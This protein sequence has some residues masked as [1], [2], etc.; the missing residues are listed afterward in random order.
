MKAK[1]ILEEA[2]NNG[3]HLEFNV[4]VSNDE[5]TSYKDIIYYRNE[6]Q[7]I[8]EAVKKLEKE[9]SE[10]KEKAILQN[11][12]IYR[13]HIRELDGIS[14]LTMTVQNKDMKLL[15]SVVDSLMNEMSNGFIF[16][17]NINPDHSVSFVA[18]SNC[19]ISAGDIV[20]EASLLSEGRGGGSP[21][22]A[23]GGGR[24]T[25]KLEEIIQ[26]IEGVIKAH[27]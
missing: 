9:Y 18:K 7:T 16:L 8:Q 5:A 15:K 2:R 24:T 3:L 27:E 13:D 6:V 17:A 1:E 22:F 19:F 23:Q 14:L 10:M 11:L 25:T 21:S 20:K 4:H 26:K 12:D